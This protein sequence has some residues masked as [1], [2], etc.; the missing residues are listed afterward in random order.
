MGL[1]PPLAGL[2]HE[3]WGKSANG[4][5]R[6]IVGGPRRSPLKFPVAKILRPQDFWL[7]VPGQHG[8][9]SATGGRRPIM[10]GPRGAEAP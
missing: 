10:G 6:P 1:R 5:R 8:G 4:G 7:V 3:S 2:P 9:N